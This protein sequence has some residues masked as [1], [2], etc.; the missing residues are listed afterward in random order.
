MAP[1]QTENPTILVVEDQPDILLL[2]Q[3]LLR[4]IITGYDV[5]SISSGADV[6]EQLRSHQISLVVT[7]YNMPG[8]NGLQVAELIK[9]TSPETG[10]II[11]TAYATPELERRARAIHVDS[12]LAKP[13]TVDRLEQAIRDTMQSKRRPGM[14]AC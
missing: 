3:R 9:A 1:S 12:F 8:M 5:V 7:D 11:L 13:F 2:L 10:I 4:D 6:A 14:F